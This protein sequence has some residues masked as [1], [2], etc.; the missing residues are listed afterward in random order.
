MATMLMTR[1]STAAVR[2]SRTAV[3]ARSLRVRMV[4]R[5]SAEPPSTETPVEASFNAA[6]KVAPTPV[7]PASPK[8]LSVG[9]EFQGGQLEALT[10]QHCLAVVGV[11]L[12]CCKPSNG[13]QCM[14]G[15]QSTV[16]PALIA[17]DSNAHKHSN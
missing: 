5:A 1:Q 12:P 7:A 2:A 9:G 10:Q 16:M 13:Q 17:V 4:V 15:Q 14:Y 11:V 6:P 3:P 8:A